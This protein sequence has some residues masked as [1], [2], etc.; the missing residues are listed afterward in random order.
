MTATRHLSLS[1]LLFPLCLGGTAPSSDSK[2]VAD[3]Y[4]EV[5]LH[6]EGMT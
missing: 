1:L 3:R 5:V 6:V 4:A 2:N